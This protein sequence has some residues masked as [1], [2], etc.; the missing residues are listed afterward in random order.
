MS[1]P[2]EFDSSIPSNLSAGLA[3]QEMIVQQMELFAYS[4]RDIFAVRLSLEEGLANSIKHGNKLDQSKMVHVNCRIDN[5]RLQVRICDEGEG[6]DPNT[7][8]DPTQEEFI[9]RP[10][11]R[12]LLLIR[13]YM[14]CSE[15]R[16][17]GRTL[18]MERE[19]NSPL[20]M[21]ED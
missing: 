11:G 8:P 5:T 1:E 12:G 20:P 9:D 17:G 6:F 14:S 18:V 19:R 7:V 15:F 21:M 2:V 16:D 3:L 13:A 4:M 10:S